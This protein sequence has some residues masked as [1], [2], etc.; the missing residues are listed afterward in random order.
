ML[1][2]PPFQGAGLGAELLTAVFA[3]YRTKS[4]VTDIA[5]DLFLIQTYL[6]TYKNAQYFSGKSFS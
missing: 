2:L 1:V 6:L 5:G 4:E 3:Y